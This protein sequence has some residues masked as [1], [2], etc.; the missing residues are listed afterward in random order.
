ML[1]IFTGGPGA[2]KTAALV[3]LLNKLPGDRPIYNDGLS[4]LNLPGKTVH[5]LDVM[6]WHETVPE[7]AVIVVDEVQR[8]WR[9]RGPSAP[10]PPSIAALET[11]RHRGVDIFVTTQAPRLVDA[12]VRA[13]CTRHVHIRDTG[14]AG[15]YWYEWPEISDQMA[16][17]TC[18]NKRKYKLPRA[19][20]SLYKSSELHTKPIRKTP[21]LLYVVLLLVAIV[22]A[23]AWA[24][25][26][27][28]TRDVS[29]AAAPKPAAGQVVS[30]L[31][32][33]GVA[34]GATAL[35]DDR[36]AWVPRISSRPES[37]PAF[38]GLRKVVAMPVVVGCAE[39]RGKA[40]CFTQQGTDAGLDDR[41]ARGLL[42]LPRFN[43]Y[44]LEAVPQGAQ[45]APVGEVAAERA[46][47]VPGLTVIDGAMQRPAAAVARKQG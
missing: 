7:G 17:R 31:S 9:P 30:S 21:K 14:W 16:W 34:P 38:D 15:R 13:L 2:G 33:G 11:H 37:A 45:Q 20:F 36:V 1:T 22:I 10:V 3:D 12:N 29:G 24:G 6:T 41:E 46:V 26:R 32:A 28:F 18:V 44:V 4:A 27:I 47:E 40:R 8:R 25:Y 42:E 43:P 19:A 35:I 5:A 39:F 23:L